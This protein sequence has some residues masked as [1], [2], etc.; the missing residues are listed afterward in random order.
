MLFNNVIG[1]CPYYGTSAIWT[2]VQRRYL[3]RNSTFVWKPDSSTMIDLQYAVWKSGEP[4]CFL[5][6]TEFCLDLVGP[7]F[8]Y[9][10]GSCSSARCVLCEFEPYWNE[11]AVKE[12]V[13]I[14]VNTTVQGG[15]NKFLVFQFLQK[16]KPLFTSKVQLTLVS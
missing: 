14:E 12:T 7:S 4:N 11:F 5:G 9:N 10:D 1:M 6:S 16:L 2:S 8:F 13:W 3:S 15:S